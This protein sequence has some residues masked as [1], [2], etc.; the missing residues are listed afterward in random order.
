MKPENLTEQWVPTSDAP[1]LASNG[2]DDEH[3]PPA[4]SDEST[5]AA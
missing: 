5:A 4:F 1:P 2:L 3:Q